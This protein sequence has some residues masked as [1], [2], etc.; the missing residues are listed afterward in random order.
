MNIQVVFEVSMWNDLCGISVYF[1]AFLFYI[2]GIMYQEFSPQIC[3]M[4]QH[5]NAFYGI[6]YYMY[7]SFCYKI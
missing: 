4:D 6:L 5:L 7:R 3:S 2:D 1:R